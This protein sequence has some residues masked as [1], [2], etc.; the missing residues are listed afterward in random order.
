[1]NEIEEITPQPAKSSNKKAAI[2]I[3]AVTVLVI[4]AVSAVLFYNAQYGPCGKKTVQETISTLYASLTKFNDAGTIANNTPRLGLPG[5]ISDMQAA[6]AEIVDTQV[7][8]CLEYAKYN[9]VA[10]CDSMI[11]G[12]LSF[13]GSESDAIV[14]RDI[15]NSVNYLEKYND[16]VERILLCAPKCDLIKVP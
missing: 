9:L 13:M 11:E 15:S 6:R 7:P 10:S 4:I 1:M 14:S 16:E 5:P 12:F 8:K 2:I 3:A